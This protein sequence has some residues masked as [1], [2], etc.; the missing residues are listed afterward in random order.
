MKIF[1]FVADTTVIDQKAVVIDII[2]SK[3]FRIL[4]YGNLNFCI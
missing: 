4:K 2:S 1:K 3:I